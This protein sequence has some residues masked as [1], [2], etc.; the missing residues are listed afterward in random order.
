[1]ERKP[2]SKMQ[3]LK[4]S[5][6]HRP[7]ELRQ[8]IAASLANFTTETTPGSAAKIA[9]YREHLESG[10]KVSVTFLPGS[11]YLETVATAKRLRREGMRP[12]PHIAARSLARR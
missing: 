6:D 3:I 7:V 5:L 4:D 2:K 12:V 9:D 11:S 10:T 8:L 1:M